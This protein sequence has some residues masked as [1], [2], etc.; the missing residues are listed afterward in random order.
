ML[1]TRN[2]TIKLIT[3]ILPVKIGKEGASVHQ[4]MDRKSKWYGQLNVI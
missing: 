2:K 1:L 3:Q 4:Q